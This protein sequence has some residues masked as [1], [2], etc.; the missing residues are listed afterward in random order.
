[1]LTGGASY[2]IFNDFLK[3][4]LDYTHRAQLH[5]LTLADDSV[6]LQAQLNF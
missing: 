5:G 1:M 2:H 6:V 3:A 4:Q